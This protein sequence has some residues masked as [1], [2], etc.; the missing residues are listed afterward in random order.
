VTLETTEPATEPA[1]LPARRAAPGDLNPVTDSWVHVVRDVTRLATQICGTDV[2]PAALRPQHEDDWQNSAARVAAVILHGR[3][4]GLPPMTA[5]AQTHVIEGRPAL[6]AEGMR[7][8]IL[9]HGHSITIAETSSARCVIRGRRKGDAD[10]TV[11]TWTIEDARRAVLLTKKGWE[12]YPRQMLL[13]RATGELARAIFPDVIHG[14][15]LLEEV[16]DAPAAGEPEP[17]PDRSQHPTVRR[18]LK[19]VPAAPPAAPSADEPPPGELGRVAAPS[20]ENGAQRPQRARPGVPRRGAQTAGDLATD[21]P[22]R[23]GGSADAPDRGG[24]GVERHAPGPAAPA[25]DQPAEPAPAP[26]PE[27]D[28]PPA[29]IDPGAQA[30]SLAQ[31]SALMGH[32]TRL[33]ATDRDERLAFTSEL[34]GREVPSTNALTVTEALV[35]LDKLAKLRDRAALDRAVAERVAGQLGATLLEDGAP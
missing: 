29:E 9:S 24:P 32:W 21:P 16:A 8:L 7:A 4:I 1:N 30:V 15:A 10:A 33:Q 20:P 26:E 2:V 31:R 17:E 13:A 34:I 11:I 19:A 18:G 27:P 28:P 14:L 22:A 6:S 23:S 35:L 5:L 12:R 25:Q 3:E